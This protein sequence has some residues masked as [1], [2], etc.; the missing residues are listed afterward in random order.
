MSI[1]CASQV[2]SCAPISSCQA[3]YFCKKKIPW[4]HMIPTAWAFQVLGRVRQP[5]P[6]DLFTGMRRTCRP[7]LSY[8]SGNFIRRS[9]R[10]APGCPGVQ[11][12]LRHLRTPKIDLDLK[13]HRITPSWF[14]PTIERAT[15]SINCASWFAAISRREALAEQ[16]LQSGRAARCRGGPSEGTSGKELFLASWH[17]TFT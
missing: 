17:C 9:V 12:S 2:R 1:V 6:R 10:F 15:G 8:L 3:G 4:S 11:L 13:R 14:V 7:C 16:R 5:L